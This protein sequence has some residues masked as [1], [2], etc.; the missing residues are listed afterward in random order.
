MKYFTE[1]PYFLPTNTE[2]IT[3]NQN[4]L[5]NN[6][7]FRQNQKNI[8]FRN[9]IDFC[10]DNSIY[11]DYWEFGCHRAR[12]FSMCLSINEFFPPQQESPF[13]RV[14]NNFYAFDSFQGLPDNNE[15]DKH[16]A[17]NTGSL[18]TS[19]I[20]FLKLLQT[21]VPSYSS[22]VE[23]I[24][25]YY[26]DTLNQDLFQQLSNVNSKISLITIDCDLYKSYKSVFNFIEP[27]LQDG[28]VIY[29]DDWNLYKGKEEFGAK[30]A[31]GEYENNSG[32]K[33]HSFMDVGWWGK[34][35]IADKK[36]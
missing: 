4:Y 28:T 6:Q 23:C 35:F 29:I 9:A 34:S 27:F 31:F 21:Y 12:T 36:R 2:A 26:E 5:P 25:G 11:G 14:L 19:K 30:K 17:W 1:E 7:S 16:V 33:F 22:N 3:L 10:R 18:C 20:D 32:Y 8:F 13:P 15:L 24:E